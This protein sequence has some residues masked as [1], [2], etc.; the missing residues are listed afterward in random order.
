[1]TRGVSVGGVKG[2]AR[3][4]ALTILQYST[5]QAAEEDSVSNQ[6]EPFSSRTRAD[7]AQRD[8]TLQ[9]SPH[10]TLPAFKCSAEPYKT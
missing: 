1:M 9:S 7:R 8:S 10:R 4:G 6:R 3:G 2:G 5:G